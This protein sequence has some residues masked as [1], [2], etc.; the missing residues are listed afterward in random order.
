MMSPEELYKWLDDL[1]LLAARIRDR[2]DD[3]CSLIE[4]TLVYLQSTILS[5]AQGDFGP[6]LSLGKYCA[7][8][9]I[10]EAET[11]RRFPEV[12]N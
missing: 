3:G 10:T 4:A 5:V 12:T 9:A 6:L 8:Q 1:E 11:R 2:E 7:Y